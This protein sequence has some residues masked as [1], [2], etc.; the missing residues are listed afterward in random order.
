MSTALIDQIESADARVREISGILREALDLCERRL[1]QAAECA[2]KAQ[3]TL[4]AA[5][6]QAEG[7]G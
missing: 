7:G 5:R 2:R 1:R 3:E 6:K 4:A